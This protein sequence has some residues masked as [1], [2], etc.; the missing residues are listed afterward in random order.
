M[1]QEIF[2]TLGFKEEEIKTYLSLLDAGP[3]SGGDL[4]KKMGMPRPTIYGYLDKLVAGGLVVQALRKSVKIYAA[5]PG[6]QLRKLYRRKIDDLRSKEKALDNIIPDL[7]KRA[8]L[9]FMRPRFQIFEGRDGMETALQDHL[10]Y[11]NMEMLAFW[12]IKAA[13]EATS[14]EFFWYMNKE[15][16]K[17]NMFLK[18]IWPVQQSV[19]VKRYPFMGVGPEFKREIRIAPQGVHASMGYWIYAN[20][21]LFSSSSKESVCFIVES[22]EL[23]EMMSSQHKVIWDMSEPIHPKPQDMKPFLDDLYADD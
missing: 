10:S 7:E 22:A 13:I 1:L 16:I 12:S 20:K 9:S 2:E 11:E 5:E 15:R 18:G 4:A 17:K 6:E 19:D 3:S 14:E 8:G 23:V 21:V